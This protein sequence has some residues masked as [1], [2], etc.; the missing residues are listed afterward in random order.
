MTREINQ[1]V[2][3]NSKIFRL[4]KKKI[5]DNS[6]DSIKKLKSLHYSNPPSNNTIDS[7]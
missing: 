6:H 5:S 2:Y 3:N 7:M 1:L 4:S